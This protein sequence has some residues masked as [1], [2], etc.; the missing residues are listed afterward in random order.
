MIPS[1]PQMHWCSREQKLPDFLSMAAK[2]EP[3]ICQLHWDPE[4]LGE[5][6]HGITVQVV[7][8]GKLGRT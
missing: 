2:M 4:Y 1:F 3:F 6:V 8:L 5:A 7:G